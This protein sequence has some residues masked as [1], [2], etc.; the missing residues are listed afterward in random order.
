MKNFFSV[1]SVVVMGCAMIVF[2]DGCGSVDSRPSPMPAPGASPT[3]APQGAFV[4]FN[5]SFSQIAGY[6]LNP[7]GTLTL[8]A[9]SPFA[10]D[11]RLA[12]AGHFLAVSSG[13][14]VSTYVV[15]PS[16][17]ALVKAGSVAVGGGLLAG[18]A[19]NLYITGDIPSTLSIGIYGF[20]LSSSGALTPLAGSPYLFDQAC[21]LCG[22]PATLGMNNDVLVL[23]G[24]GFHSA[25]TF[26][27]YPRMTTGVLGKRQMLGADLE[28]HVAIQHPAGK[29]SYALST[30]ASTLSEFTLDNTGNAIAGPQ[31]L[32]GSGQDMT[33][34]ATGRFLLLVDEAGAIRV[35]SIDSASGALNQIGISETAGNG[36]FGITMD[37]SG[38]FVIVSQS[39][40][41][42]SLPGA[43]SQITVFTF[44]P[45]TGAI[46]KL[47][48]YPLAAP[49]GAAVMIAP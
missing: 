47:Q 2:L 1:W 12:A 19:D 39:A 43:R 26:T 33:V 18:D 40:F 3:P 5:N 45:A 48:S 34:D 10:I 16:S 7:D 11:G 27:V 8:L 24:G 22:Q 21:D 9:G 6:R 25:G 37:P 29:F 36:A 38:H 17:G 15:D 23:G 14:A 31:L 41:S 4:Y 13:T 42:G 32:I 28:V 30:D 44:D 20:A 49:P 35:F 46:K